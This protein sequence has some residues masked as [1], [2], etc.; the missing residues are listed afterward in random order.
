MEKHG[1]KGTFLYCLS[2]HIY[3]FHILSD[4]KKVKDLL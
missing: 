2:L 4:G 1:K 3:A